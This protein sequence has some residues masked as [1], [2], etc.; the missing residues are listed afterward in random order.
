MTEINYNPLYKMRVHGSIKIL[1]YKKINTWGGGKAL[2]CRRM[3]TNKYR[4]NDRVRQWSF[5]NLIV[6]IYS[7]KNYQWILM[8]FAENLMANRISTQSFK[9][10]LP[11]DFLLI[12]K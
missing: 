6:I 5:C 12:T 3:S 4:G 7:D 2:S 8:L 1:A 11:T 10:C 9:K